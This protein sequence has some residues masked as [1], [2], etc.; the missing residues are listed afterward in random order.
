LEIS[1]L[2]QMRPGVVRLMNAIR[3]ITSLSVGVSPDSVMQSSDQTAMP[4][5]AIILR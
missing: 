3:S 4:S 5:H 1:E 2:A